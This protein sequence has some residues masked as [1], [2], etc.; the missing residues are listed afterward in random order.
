MTSGA[1]KAKT[2]G[3]GKRATKIK[4]TPKGKP[5][6]KAAK[7]V[8]F[9]PKSQEFIGMVGNELQI[10][11][12]RDANLA[13]LAQQYRRAGVGHVRIA[14][15]WNAIEP[16]P[17]RFDW[18]YS[19]LK[20][21]AVADVGLRTLGIFGNTPQ[22][23]S[24]CPNLTGP[25]EVPLFTICIASN[26]DFYRNY[27]RRTVRRY[28]P[29]GTGQIRDWEIR[30]ES[31]PVSSQPEAYGVEDYVAEAN[32]AFEVIR[33][34]DPGARVWV[35][36]YAFGRFNFDQAMAWTTYVAEHASFDIHSIHHF[37]TPAQ[38]L[39][40]TKAVRQTLN[41]FGLSEKPLA[42][43]AMSVFVANP[44]HYT[45]EMQAA[46]LHDVYTSAWAG[47]AEYAMW[48]AGTQWPDL[49][50]KKYGV[51]RYDFGVPDKVVPRIAY[52]ALQDLG[53]RLPAPPPRAVPYGCLGVSSN[54]A[55]AAG[56]QA[57]VLLYYYSTGLGRPFVTVREGTQ[58]I[59]CDKSNRAGVVHLTVPRGTSR[60]LTLHPARS[61]DD[62]RTNARLLA[63]VTVEALP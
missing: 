1:R 47:G 6:K 18:G 12:A 61:C 55:I 27:V 44:A 7:A 24:S 42:V 8:A 26:L 39:S 50:D 51:F 40:F 21:S 60:T 29:A 25:G 41:Q 4:K 14:L 49:Q 62:M 33:E 54:P 30:V 10:A 17:G 9:A 38:V 32:A 45:E 16:V 15:N 57:E 59:A 20:V 53:A 37:N 19:D 63:R 52:K 22:W 48:F 43:T 23:A 5:A 3:N 28:G 46:S 31:N 36:E 13:Y 34:E 58:Q 56:V 2:A 11:V 35:G